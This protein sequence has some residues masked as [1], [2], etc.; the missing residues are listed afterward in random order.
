MQASVRLFNTRVIE[1]SWSKGLLPFIIK[2]TGCFLCGWT[3]DVDKTHIFMRKE[4]P[5]EESTSSFSFK[6]KT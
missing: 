4:G 2:A 1:V 3:S 6:D 5:E